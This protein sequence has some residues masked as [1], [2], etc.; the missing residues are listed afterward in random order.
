MNPPKLGSAVL[1]FVTV[2]ATKTEPEHVVAHEGILI[3]YDRIRPEQDKDS[4][5]DAH[6][7]YANKN[8]LQHFNTSDWN[9]AFDR[10]DSIPYGNK[11]AYRYWLTGKETPVGGKDY[12][13]TISDMNKGI[14]ILKEQ[15][16]KAT[17]RAEAAEREL[18]QLK[19]QPSSADL[20]TVEA[21][22]DA[23]KATTE[24]KTKDK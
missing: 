14:E 11:N 15:L 9:L 21:E 22:K 2:P 6:I 7:I 3:G 8:R 20:D 13:K 4:L 10:A 12:E 17:D 24:K 16:Q 23:K 5:P 19:S 1:V 18:A